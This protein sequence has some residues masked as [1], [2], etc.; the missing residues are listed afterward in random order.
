MLNKEYLLPEGCAYIRNQFKDMKY[1]EVY[2]KF[3]LEECMRRDPKGLY[4]KAQTGIIVNY[5]GISS[6]FEEPDNPDLILDTSD[7][8]IDDSVAR[9]PVYLK[10]IDFLKDSRMRNNKT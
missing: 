3:D 8:N 2:V 9:V 5:T 4:K 6:L 7:L 10:V 1:I